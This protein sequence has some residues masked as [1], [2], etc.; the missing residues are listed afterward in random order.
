MLEKL[1]QII[2]SYSELEA[3][4][5]DPEVLSDQKEYTRLA[6]EHSSQA[7]LVKLARTYVSASSD[8]SDARELLRSESNAE[9][10][11]FAQ[12]EISDLTEQI[13]AL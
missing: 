6:K 13:T 4:L 12:Q 1:L 3:R 2:E 9:M 7:D 11:E 10:K 8:L 5:G